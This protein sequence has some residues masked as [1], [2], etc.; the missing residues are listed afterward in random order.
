MGRH[1]EERRWVARPPPCSPEDVANVADI[2][3]KLARSRPRGSQAD[4]SYLLPCLSGQRA[5]GP[6]RSFFP[7]TQTAGL[8]RPSPLP[9]S[10]FP[11]LIYL[12]HGNQL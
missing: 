3:R 5:G 2:G 8:P 10:E 7:R 1:S 6:S 4:A 12:Y 11:T 9:G